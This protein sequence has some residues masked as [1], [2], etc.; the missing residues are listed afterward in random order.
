M[1]AGDLQRAGIT[2]ALS[3][4]HAHRL[5]CQ[6]QKL[7]PGKGAGK[8]CWRIALLLFL[9]MGSARTYFQKAATL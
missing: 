9:R 6:A 3:A 7:W 4:P 1:N 2:S 8:C 5:V